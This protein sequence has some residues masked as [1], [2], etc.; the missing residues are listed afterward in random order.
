[1]CLKKPIN[2]EVLNMITNK[3]EAKKPQNISDVVLNANPTVQLVIQI[4]NEII[5]HT[6]LNKKINVSVKKIIVGILS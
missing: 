3:N 5:K 2:F 6:S 4:K 1:M